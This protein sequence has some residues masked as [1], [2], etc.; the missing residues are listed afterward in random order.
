M[1]TLILGTGRSGLAVASYLLR[2]GRSVTVSD[3]RSRAET[4]ETPLWPSFRELEQK[5][6][7]RLRWAFGGHPVSLLDECEEVVISPGVSLHVPFLQEALGRRV[8]VTGEMELAYTACPKPVV[9][10]TG[11]NGKSTTCS[12]LGEMLGDRGVVGG[13]IGIPLLDQVQALAPA[14]DWVVAEVSSFQLETVHTFRPKI[15]ILTNITPDHLDHHKDLREYEVAKSRMFA[16]MG[17]GDC[18]IFCADDANAMRIKAMV[19]EGSLPSW[20]DGFPAP[21]NEDRPSI[22]TYSTQG[23]VENGVA[24]EK[25]GET[26]WVT[27]YRNGEPQRLFPWGFAGLPGNAMVGN[28][29]AAITAALEIGLSVDKI[30]DALRR[31]QPLHYRMEHAGAVDG[32]VFVN[33]SKATNID[34]ALA[35]ALSIEGSLAVIVGGKDKGVDYAALAE[36]LASREGRVFLIGEAAEPIERCFKELDFKN[37]VLSET[38]DRAINQAADF[39]SPEGGTVLL[40]PAC[41]SFDQFKS[42]EHRGEIFNQ[43]VEQ[44]IKARSDKA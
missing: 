41:S 12:L 37:Y 28:G 35:S 13:N 33:D 25:S 29:L 4:E 20:V 9:A 1:N 22:R 39:L 14:V 36:G 15:A 6:G 7:Q 31:F 26:L 17:A 5:Y 23:T 40:A 44:L 27:L 21:R 18:A 19:E 43:L 42:A 34:S 16:Q 32:I 2:Q 24:L 11:T 38:M 3:Q 8:R 30:Q 10:V